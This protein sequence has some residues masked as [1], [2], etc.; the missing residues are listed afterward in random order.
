MYTKYA[1]ASN[2]TPSCT[3]VSSYVSEESTPGR[4]SSLTC[5]ILQLFGASLF[6]LISL[7]KQHC[8]L[9]M[10][11]TERTRKYLKVP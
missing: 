9:D 11:T 3:H 4:N 6:E 5:C 10:A 1:Y 7:K 2:N 8:H